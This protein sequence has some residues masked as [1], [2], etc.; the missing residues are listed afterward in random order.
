MHPS[1][2][3]RSF[4]ACL[5]P[6]SLLFTGWACSGSD[7][8]GG[9]G[10]GAASVEAT[11]S[12]QETLE[13]W[14]LGEEPLLEIGVREGEEPYQLF[15]A[16]GAVRLDDGRIVVVNGGSQEL[17]FFDARG[18]FLQAV[19]GDGEGPGEF[20][21]PAWIRKAGLDSLLVWDQG[22]QRV[23]FFDDSGDF[24]GSRPLHPTT[25]VLFPG[26][27]WI[28]RSFWIDSPVRP[29]AR[30]PLRRAADA[31]PVPDSVTGLVF[32]KVTAQ[33]RIWAS[34]VRP[35]T[36]AV[37]DWSVYDL[38]GRPVARIR[39]PARFEPFEIGPDYVVGR[40]R[41]DLDIDYIR[42]YA[43]EKPAGSPSGPGLDFAPPAVSPRPKT[44]LSTEEQALLA[45]LK[46]LMKN[47]ASLEEIYYSEHYTY[48]TDLD[49][50]F[51]ETRTKVPAGVTVSVFFAV[52]EGWMGRVTDDD[53]GRFCVLTYGFYV[54]MGWV[55]GMVL[56]P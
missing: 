14:T 18:Q 5:L 11:Q 19:G 10:S 20:R 13:S 9:G 12:G 36:D 23:S 47:M 2:R 56:C 26:D 52:P 31:I 38:D 22:L 21:Y 55:P 1:P 29:E 4:C 48:T 32:L 53:S 27:E 43:L 39:T 33:G 35:P 8:A 17:R 37:L 54:P 28:Y 6:A 42:V 49:A 50:L 24:L 7:Q 34:E 41:D 25:E 40:Y 3:L 30:E 44:V 45:P 51:S 16:Q 15:R 46:S